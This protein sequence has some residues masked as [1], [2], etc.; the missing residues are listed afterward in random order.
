MDSPNTSTTNWRTLGISVGAVLLAVGGQPIVNFFSG[1]ASVRSLIP[2]IVTCILGF[3]LI[4]VSV[5]YRPK[6]ENKLFQRLGA[7]SSSPAPYALILLLI[8]IYFETAAIQRNNEIVTLRNDEETIAKVIDRLVLPRH[9]TNNQQ[10]AISSFLRQF[11]PHEYA[12]KLPLRYEEA[13]SYR[14]D[15]EQALM[16][17]GWTRSATNPYVYTDDLPEGL[18]I[19]FIQ[20]MEHAQKQSDWRNPSASL[21]LQEA[22][23][24]AGVRVDQTG[25]GSGI[26]VSEDRLEIGIGRPRKDAYVLTLP[27]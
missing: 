11:E 20:T 4:L 16:K 14:V 24:I 21:L 25:G 1:D 6:P 19:N 9:L 13:G 23:G 10:K 15:I 27:D 3:T 22:L 2:G 26:N 18:S 12:F 8:W 17:G 7:W 5:I